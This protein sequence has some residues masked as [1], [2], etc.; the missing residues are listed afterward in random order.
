MADVG[1][2]AE[3]GV[4]IL[5]EREDV[6]GVPQFVVRFGSAPGVAMNPGCDVVFLDEF[7]DQIDLIGGGFNGDGANTELFREVEDAAGSGFV[8]GNSHDAEIYDKQSVLPG[9]GF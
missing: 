7:V 8:A 5:D 9:F 3:T 2:D 1:A 6:V 4:M